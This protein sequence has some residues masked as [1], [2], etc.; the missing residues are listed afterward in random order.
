MQILN[1]F[2]EFFFFHSNLSNNDIISAQR[3]GLKMGMDFRGLGPVS[4]KSR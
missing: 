2:E 1:G 3:L 4:R